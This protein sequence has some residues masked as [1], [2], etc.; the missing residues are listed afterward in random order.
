MLVRASGGRELVA[1]ACDRCARLGVRAGMPLSDARA[2]VPMGVLGRLSL[3]R[4]RPGH[5]RAG[6]LR[7]ARWCLRWSPVVMPVLPDAARGVACG[8]LVL[9]I[10][11]TQMLHPSEAHLLARVSGALA[12]AGVRASLAIAGTL[13]AAWALACGG[14]HGG[15]P[16]IVPAGATRAQ[17]QGA[18]A[19]LSVGSLR[20]SPGLLEKLRGL[21]IERVE[22]VLAIPRARLARTLG[23]E[24]L[25]RLDQAM[26]LVDE[27]IEGIK[28]TRAARVERVLTGPTDRPEAVARIACGLIGPLL[29]E[30]GARGRGVREMSLRLRSG[31]P[32]HVPDV[33]VGVTLGRVCGS[34]RHLRR[35]LLARLERTD[36]SGGVESLVLTAPRTGLLGGVQGRLLASGD[37]GAG[38]PAGEAEAGLAGHVAELAEVLQTRLGAGAVLRARVL[39]G[40]IPERAFAL[41]AW[42]QDAGEQDECG[43]GHGR[44][45]GVG[46]GG[47]GDAGHASGWADRPTVLLTRPEAAEVVFLHPGGPVA[48]VTWRGEAMEAAWCRGPEHIEDAWW[49]RGPDER[50]AGRTYYVVGTTSGRTL[51]VC[52]WSASGAGGVGGEGW[53][54]QGEWA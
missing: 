45:V 11:G 15:A 30:L 7:L 35:L 14:V 38:G 4:H 52:R 6:L 2:L 9:D 31:Q 49:A 37:A 34:E 51:W 42:G 19:G 29:A 17:V 40:H 23:L 28:V 8:G 46:F 41:E 24:V 20:L 53:A 32:R 54:V 33:R 47:G 3:V 36:V 13:G 10:S 5:D 16:V 1:H 21:R 27:P 22:Q 39:A 48:R 26:G 12:R 50:R 43:G 25:T 18:L 44:G